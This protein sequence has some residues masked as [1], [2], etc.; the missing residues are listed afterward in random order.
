[1]PDI[2]AMSSSRVFVCRFA[3]V[4]SLLFPSPFISLCLTRVVHSCATVKEASLGRTGCT[5][6]CL[7]SF[8][9][10]LHC[11]HVLTRCACLAAWVNDSC[12]A[13]C[14]RVRLSVEMSVLVAGD[15]WLV[16]GRKGGWGWDR[17]DCL[18]RWGR[19]FRIEVV[20]WQRLRHWSSFH[21]SGSLVTFALSCCVRSLSSCSPCEDSTTS[22]DC[23]VAASIFGS[24]CM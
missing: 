9:H 23:T 3:C 8:F 16:V 13:A 24:T 19:L 17:Q 10:M 6:C 11:S 15:A 1:M 14:S 18:S 21:P 20:C 22:N 5:K 7:T 4:D 2:F 12:C